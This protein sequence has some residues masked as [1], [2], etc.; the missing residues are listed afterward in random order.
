[1]PIKSKSDAQ[2]RADQI[3][4]FRAELECMENEKVLSLDAN[5]RAAIATYHDALL[6]RLSTA[7]DIDSSKRWKLRWIGILIIWNGWNWLEAGSMLSG[8]KRTM[9][10]GF[11]HDI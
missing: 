5:Q 8:L 1:M 3:R 7:F 4:Q 10:S 11:D 2:R 9:A 6:G